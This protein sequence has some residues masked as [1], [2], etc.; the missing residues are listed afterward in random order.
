MAASKN[1]KQ[2]AR[3]DGMDLS[4]VEARLDTVIR[5]LAMSVAPDDLTL[6]ERAIRLQRAGM[7]PKD[8]ADLCETTSNTVSVVLSSAKKSKS[9]KAKK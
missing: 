5:L 8:I 4:G 9:K 6:K 3:T 7:A 2:P 1:V